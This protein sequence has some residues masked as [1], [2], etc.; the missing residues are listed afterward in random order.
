MDAEDFYLAEL[1]SYFRFL[2][3]QEILKNVNLDMRLEL[4]SG[5]RNK[6]FG[7]VD[8]NWQNTLVMNINKY[9][10]TNF[11]VQLLYDDDIKIEKVE[12]G[13]VTQSGPM[14][15]FKSAFGI[16]LVYQL[17]ANRVE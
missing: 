5:Y 2:Y 17:G 6:S 10:S 12:N 11:F 9:L 15:Q 3:K 4:F 7:N 13:V 14:I 16:G 1:G 8:V